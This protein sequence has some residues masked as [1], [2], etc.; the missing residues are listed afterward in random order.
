MDLAWAGKKA[1]SDPLEDGAIALKRPDFLLEALSGAKV[2]TWRLEIATGLV[3]WDE[4]TG[5]ILGLESAP[6]TTSAI[7]PVHQDDQRRLAANLKHSIRTGIPKDIEFRG[8]RSDGKVRWLHAV[9]QPIKIEGETPRYVAGIVSDITDRKNAELALHESERRLQTIINNLPGVAYRCGVHAPRPVLFISAGITILT[10]YSPD[11]FLSGRVNSSLIHPDDISI[12]NSTIETAV[13]SKTQYRIRYRLLHLS[14]EYRWVYECGSAAYD[15]AGHALFLEGFMGDIHDRHI[16]AQKLEETTERYRLASRATRD[17]IWDW[18]LL[19]DEITWSEALS[20]ELGY[21][22]ADRGSSGEWWKARVHPSERD[23]VVRTVDAVRCDGGAQFNME[24]RFRRA[25]GTYAPMYDRGFVIRDQ[26]GR[27]I[28]MVGAMQDLTEQMEASAALNESEM[29]NRGVLDASADCIMIIAL[30]GVLLFMN[31]PGQ[32]ALEI[33]DFEAL[34]GEEWAKLWPGQMA[35][36]VRSAVKEAKEGRVARF[37]GFCPVADG[38]PK[39]WDIVLTPMRNDAGKVVRLLSI[40]R[41]ITESRRTSEE[42]RW[43][44]EHDDLTHLP[45]RRAFEAHLRTATIRAMKNDTNVGLLLIDLD[46]F[47]HVNDTLGHAAGDYLLRTF[48]NRLVECVRDQD[49]VARLGGDEFAVIIQDLSGESDLHNVGEAISARFREPVTFDGRIVGAS[50]SIGGALFPRDADCANEMFK[51]ADTALYALKAAGRGGTKLFRSYM[52]EQVERAAA[53]LGSARLA[54]SQGCIRPHYQPKVDLKSGQVV[55]F[56]ALLR[57]KQHNE[58]IQLPESIAEAFNDYELAA[59]ISEIMHTRIF[60]DMNRWQER[61]V[62]F[63][64]V[65]INAAPVE[66]LRDDY[67]ERL[68]ERLRRHG[69]SPDL[70]EVEITEQVFLERGNDFV[71]R[72]LEL[73]SHSGVRV[74]LDDFGTGYSSLSH[75]RDYPVDIIKIDRTFIGQMIDEPEM[76]LI[77]SAV[78]DL[79]GSLSI[80]VVAEGIETEGQANFLIAKGCAFGQG[81]LYGRAADAEEVPALSGLGRQVVLPN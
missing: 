60:A 74:S 3:T 76:A 8:H 56:E 19:T 38:T 34:K 63:G 30:D 53:Q 18:D 67:A 24:Y 7:L 13:T 37:S 12:V 71:R 69:L 48:G 31:D 54:I 35:P 1:G 47:K 68:L 21:C 81:Y 10:G 28:R 40:A 65:S 26:S 80:E 41:D 52:R 57:W 51:R 11:D 23:R 45:N 55:G 17:L 46:H 15:D 62:K 39:W 32:R 73:L 50:A 36:T 5:E 78:I 58:E 64:R 61:R 77:V 22:E 14:G 6:F 70:I 72:A 66:F 43:A 27:A 29:L 42:L 59:R 44:S 4:G 2:G 79:A 49:F 25:D 9:V 33:D 20:T 16:A 75:L